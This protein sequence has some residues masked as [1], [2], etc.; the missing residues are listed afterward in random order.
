MIQKLKQKI[1][2]MRVRAADARYFAEYEYQKN[3]YQ[4]L[5]KEADGKN[6]QH[7]HSI[8]KG[9]SVRGK[10][11]CFTY[12]QIAKELRNP[13]SLSL[14][15][16]VLYVV[17]KDCDQTLFA[18]DFE[19]CLKA[20]ESK[21]SLIYWDEDVLKADGVVSHEPYL[22]PDMSVQTLY[23]FFYLGSCFAVKS[24]VL[25][26][27]LSAVSSWEICRA[28]D[29]DKQ[30]NNQICESAAVYAVVLWLSQKHRF[31]HIERVLSHQKDAIPFWGMEKD[32]VCVKQAFFE[33][34]GIKADCLPAGYA[35]WQSVVYDVQSDMTENASD[36]GRKS[37]PAEV[38][39]VSI[40]IP[41]KDHPQVLKT[42][43]TSIRKHTSK[44]KPEIIVIDNGS[45][46]ENKQRIKKL[47][48]EWDFTYLYEPMEFDF[49]R[50]NNLAAKQAKGEYL[51]LCNDDIEVPD[52]DSDWLYRMLG[53]AM[54]PGIGA[55]GAKLLYPE[56]NRIQHAGISAIGYEVGPAHKMLGY[57][58]HTDY[59]FGRN[60]LT[61]NVIGVTAACLLVK[62]AH[63][64]QAGGLPETMKVAYN[65][66][67][68][69]YKLHSLGYANVQ[70]N[71]VVL[72]H[73]ESLSRGDDR[74]DEKKWERLL[75]EKEIL[76]KDFPQICRRDPYYNVNL[77]TN[78]DSFVCHYLYPYENRDLFSRVVK[79]ARAIP[80]KW[81]NN[82]LNLTVEHAV[83]DKRM[84]RTEEE[85]F[86]IE[87][88]WYVLGMDNA[89][90]KATV[91]L[92]PK[93]G[94]PVYVSVF[95]RYRKDVEEILEQQ[96]V[97]LSGFV[98]RIK[99]GDLPKGTYRIGLL[100]K[101]SCSRQKLYKEEEQTITIA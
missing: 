78:K 5:L 47:S 75:I 45:N 20:A 85:R 19:D 18:Q 64:E 30:K 39:L 93:E 46:E 52:T 38:P 6:Y 88:W 12:A 76:Y 62:K 87:G 86:W 92:T 22:K 53:Q 1:L 60:H 8:P 84:H 49:S 34:A 10:I 100:L 74:M 79:N 71:D 58:D 16:D 17:L 68:F 96:N 32:Y 35:D 95:I 90:Y 9:E 81:H 42:C 13:G 3:P 57:E 25:K 98:C 56:G 80:P 14:N 37:L 11:G 54:Q 82:C 41:S 21:A 61:Y 63:Y 70:R 66:V 4:N 15:D 65:D 51:L 44:V 94:N 29:E 83:W 2:Q 67:S 28:K 99:K 77:T 27:A 36:I 23:S 50:M 91:V 97:G 55:V 43:V 48:R 73:H 24:E 40:L 33:Q 72:I 7:Y 59:Y 31:T 26:K 89:R 69:C 101:D